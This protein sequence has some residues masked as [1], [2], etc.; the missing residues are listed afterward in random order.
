MPKF[1][2]LDLSDISSYAS[3]GIDNYFP[4]MGEY[5]SELRHLEVA[6]VWL[7]TDGAMHG[8]RLNGHSEFMLSGELCVMDYFE[9]PETHTHTVVESESPLPSQTDIG[10]LPGT[11]SAKNQLGGAND[12]L[13]TPLLPNKQGLVRL[14]VETASKETLVLLC[15]ALSLHDIHVWLLRVI[16][17]W[18]I[19]SIW[20]SRSGL[21]YIAK[22]KGVDEVILPD[23]I[24]YASDWLVV[25]ESLA[26]PSQVDIDRI[27][28]KISALGTDALSPTEKWMLQRF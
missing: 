27:L 11:H 20:L 24:K 23:E 6:K 21:T 15:K 12:S 17:M 9:L 16:V 28:E 10:T 18:G 1:F 13:N 14:H 8:Y 22:M 2:T 4:R 7:D 19:E 25:W 26:L 3:A 5:L